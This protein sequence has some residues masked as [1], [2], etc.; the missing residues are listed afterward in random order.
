MR[1]LI[2]FFFDFC[3]F[4][5]LLLGRKTPIKMMDRDRDVCLF[6]SR[7]WKRVR[8]KQ[9]ARWVVQRHEDAIA[10]SRCCCWWRWRWRCLFVFN[11]GQ[12]FRRQISLVS[13]IGCFDVLRLPWTAVTEKARYCPSYSYSYSRSLERKS[14]RVSTPR[15]LKHKVVQRYVLRSYTTNEKGLMSKKAV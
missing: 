5:S 6:Q 15:A 8:P 1:V 14:S 12:S 11:F 2:F 10:A 9:N 4:R 7:V 13:K 3:L